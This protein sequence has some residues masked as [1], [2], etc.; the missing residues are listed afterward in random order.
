VKR[1][2]R[3]S[4]PSTKDQEKAKKRAEKEEKDRQARVTAHRRI[5]A[6]G[7]RAPWPF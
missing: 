5:V 2:D 4:V 3:P 7:P 6:K 1:R